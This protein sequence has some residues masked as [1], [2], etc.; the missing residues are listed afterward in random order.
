MEVKLNIDTK[1]HYGRQIFI[2]NVILSQKGDITVNSVLAECEKRGANIKVASI[3]L[4]LS[5]L[6]ERGE[7]VRYKDHYE[8]YK[9]L[10]NNNKN[11]KK[12]NGQEVER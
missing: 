6:I 10:F 12:D 4:C 11:A 7:I 3:V 5:T 2:T 1:T 9:G 8:I